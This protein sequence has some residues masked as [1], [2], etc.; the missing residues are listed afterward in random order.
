M[1]EQ[2]P[3]TSESPGRLPLLRPGELDVRQQA[4]RESIVGGPRVGQPFRTCT[5]DGEL[6]GPFNALLYAPELGEAVQRIGELLRF[7]GRLP[8]RLRELVI[9]AVASACGSDYEWYAHSRVAE[10]LGVTEEEL[11]ALSVGEVPQECDRA[12]TAGVKMCLELVRSSRVDEET[13]EQTRRC[14]DEAEI[15][16]LTVL[17]GYYRLLSG[18]LATFDVGAPD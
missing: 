10:G 14:F 11:A 17:V 1:S 13:Y 18:M 3:E 2:H 7:D 9:L 5:D 8:A 16:E 6:L 15:V 12:E 4:L